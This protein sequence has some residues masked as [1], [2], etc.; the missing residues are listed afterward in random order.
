[1]DSVIYTISL[2]QSQSYR[3]FWHLTRHIS[4]WQLSVKKS[5]LIKLYGQALKFS[6]YVFLPMYHFCEANFNSFSRMVA[7]RRIIIKGLKEQRKHTILKDFHAHYSHSLDTN[8]P[9]AGHCY[10]YSSEMDPGSQD[11]IA[12]VS[13]CLNLHSYLLTRL[14]KLMNRWSRIVK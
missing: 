8:T 9:W 2:D 14:C 7:P 11:H 12:S 10:F 4:W 6:F 1:M 5:F 13:K 3:S